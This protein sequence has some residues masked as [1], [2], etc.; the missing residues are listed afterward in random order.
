ME[1]P[2][3][4]VLC[5]AG[6]A[7]CLGQ[8]ALAGG[9]QWSAYLKLLEESRW[10]G[11]QLPG[12]LLGWAG[13]R[14]AAP[15]SQAAGRGSVTRAAAAECLHPPAA[16][17]ANPSRACCPS[18]LPPPPPSFVHTMTLDFLC[19]TSL[20]PFWMANDAQ[21][22]RWDKAD[23]LLPVLSVIPVLGPALYL[24]LRPRAQL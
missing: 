12:C 3:I 19:L 15:G 13:G 5:L 18:S 7:A 9:A 11:G 4:G 2:L 6:G 20:A 22:R 16:G 1:S 24:C 10:V 21:L 17:P 8:A 23:S 14:G